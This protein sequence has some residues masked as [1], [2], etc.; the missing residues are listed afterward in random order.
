VVGPTLRNVL[1]NYPQLAALFGTAPQNDRGSTDTKP[2][3]TA[4]P[5]TSTT[6]SSTSNAGASGRSE[7]RTANRS[8]RSAA[9][10]SPRTEDSTPAGTADVSPSAMLHAL[11]IQQALTPDEQA[12]V[13]GIAS[14][15]TDS[16][17][18]VWLTELAKLDVPAGVAKVREFL[19]TDSTSKTKAVV[20]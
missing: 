18:A 7:E 20:S 15:M 14:V 2:E 11:E 3:R 5:S 9:S 13:Q 12:K 10:S 16:E 17:R 8:D 1:S 19:A 4:E 6:R